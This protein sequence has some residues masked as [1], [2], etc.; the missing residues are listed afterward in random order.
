MTVER[1]QR[2][3]LVE[4]QEQVRGMISA[5]LGANGFD[6]AAVAGIDDAMTA[7]S[8]RG[9]FDLVLSDVRLASGRNGIE[10]ADWMREHASDVAVVLMSAL[11]DASLASYRFLQKPFT[12]S[13]LMDTLG[14]ALSA[15]RA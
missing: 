3:L 11:S 2:I 9:A 14:C 10:L 5:V 6:V 7:L 8:D 12:E 1:G 13:E 4:D 15:E